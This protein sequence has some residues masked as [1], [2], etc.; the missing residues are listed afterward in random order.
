M[1]RV[2]YGTAWEG[3]LELLK[4]FFLTKY[5][6]KLIFGGLTLLIEALNPFADEPTDHSLIAGELTL[7]DGETTDL[8]A[9]EPT[10]SLK[11]PASH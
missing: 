3:D 5:H 7:H 1:I 6:N 4:K 11:V 2:N 8:R 10:A 9:S